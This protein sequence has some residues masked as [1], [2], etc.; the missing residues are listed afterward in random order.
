[1]S[2]ARSC[3]RGCLVNFS[4]VCLLQPSTGLSS[5]SETLIMVYSRRSSQLKRPSHA[6]RKDRKSLLRRPARPSRKLRRYRWWT[7]KARALTGWQI[8]NL[9]LSTNLCKHPS[10]FSV[11]S[12]RREYMPS[13]V[14]HKMKHRS[15][16]RKLKSLRRRWM[17]RIW[18]ISG[19][20][21]PR[22]GKQKRRQRLPI[23]SR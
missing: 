18:S 19:W 21:R 5:I 13:Q 9:T 15:L 17:Q 4:R 8:A 7:M 1:M 2:T 22:N 23:I 16:W 6:R 20:R 11:T 12:A 10:I 3:M 14:Y